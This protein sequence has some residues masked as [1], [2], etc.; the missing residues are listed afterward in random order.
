MVAHV[1]DVLAREAPPRHELEEEDALAWRELFAR[2]REVPG[3]VV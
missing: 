3:A 1:E 2:A